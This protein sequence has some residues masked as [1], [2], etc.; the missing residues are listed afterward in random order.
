ME[1][2]LALFPLN[3]VLFPGATLPLHI[4]E[5]RY[6][7]MISRCMQLKNPFGVVLIREGQEVGG[8]A[9]PYPVGTTAV[10]QNALRFP[11]GQM[12]ISAQGEQ[13]FRIVQIIQSDPYLVASVEFMEEEITPEVPALAKHVREL[14]DK[15]RHAVEHATGITQ[16]L[17]YLPQDPATL[18]Y[19]LSDQFRIINYSKQQL[20]EADLEQR[21]TAIVEAFDR[22]LRFL[23]PPPQMPSQTND[24]PWTLN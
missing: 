18:S 22:E 7:Q 4:F 16:P 14:Y 3:T 21:L 20:L 2:L 12:L 19:R 10:I 13:R 24:G 17:E 5:Q 9:E 11:D 8:T 23:P 6:R 15:H 1:Q